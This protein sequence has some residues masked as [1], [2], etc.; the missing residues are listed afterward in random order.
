M[1][2][3]AKRMPAREA[4]YRRLVLNPRI[5]ASSPFVMPAQWKAC[6][7]EPLDLRGRDVFAGLDLSETRDLTAL[8]LLGQDIRDGTWHVVPT[9]W[10]PAE[11]LHDKAKSDRVPYDTWAAK[12]FLQTT[13]GSSVSYEYVAQYLKGVFRS[14]PRRQDRV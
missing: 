1:A 11:G 2:S 5:E 7:G 8:V 6:A 12:G 14:A 10:L 9:F 3:D 13:Q 4:A